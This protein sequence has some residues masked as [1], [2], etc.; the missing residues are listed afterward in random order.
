M[1][2]AAVKLRCGLMA[3]VLALLSAFAFGATQNAVAAGGCPGPLTTPF[4]PWG[5]SDQYWLAPNG[6]FEGKSAWT[7]TGGATIATGNETFSVHKKKDSHSLSIP[8]GGSAVTPEICVTLSSPQ[9]RFFA[10]GGNS[11][12]PLKVDVIA[13]T[14]YGTVQGKTAS[15]AASPVWAPTPQIALASPDGTT[16]VQFRFS[17]PG[18]AAWTIDDVYV[19]PWKL[20]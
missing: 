4:L 7:L 2:P 6:D 12:S 13:T 8:P 18:T 20:K 9:M 1:A 16:S 5:D 3:S 11:T 14:P 10:T 19:D 15:V 17:N